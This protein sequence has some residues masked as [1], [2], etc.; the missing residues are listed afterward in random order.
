MTD[1]AG[2]WLTIRRTSDVDMQER[3][4]YV[5]LDGR[6]LGILRYGDSATVPIAAGHHQLRVHNTWSRRHIAFDAM[7]GQELRFSTANVRGAGFAYL[8]IFVGAAFMHTVL[9]REEDG[10]PTAD[11]TP[12][13]FRY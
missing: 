3:E 2:A 6:R 4:L 10:S 1:P 8:A 5:S 12:R 13:P 11:P 9:E 7:P